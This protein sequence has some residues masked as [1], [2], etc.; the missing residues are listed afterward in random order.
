VPRWHPSGAL[1]HIVKI[2]QIRADTLFLSL[3]CSPKLPSTKQ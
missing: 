3:I 2:P 1:I